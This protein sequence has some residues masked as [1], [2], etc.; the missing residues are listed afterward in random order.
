MSDKCSAVSTIDRDT[1]ILEVVISM[2]L[3]TVA[4][5]QT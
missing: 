4:G 2:T 5:T 1:E 3:L